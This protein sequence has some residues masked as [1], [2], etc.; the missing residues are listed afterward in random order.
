METEEATNETQPL[1]EP[2]ETGKLDDDVNMNLS[3][4]SDTSLVSSDDGGMGAVTPPTEPSEPS[5]VNVSDISSDLDNEPPVAVE[6]GE[7][8]VNLSEKAGDG[9][10]NVAQEVEAAVSVGEPESKEDVPSNQPVVAMDTVNKDVSEGKSADGAE[11][12]KTEAISEVSSIQ[13]S[14]DMPHPLSAEAV[15]LQGSAPPSPT[16]AGT[17]TKTPGKRKVTRNMSFAENNWQ[18]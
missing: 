1:T 15:S 18:I 8:P 9:D 2:P 7:N 3:S 5:L 10:D 6:K 4:V 14:D 11:L 12:S 16:S 17:P 13:P